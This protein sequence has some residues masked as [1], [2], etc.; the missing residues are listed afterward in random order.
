MS[1]TVVLH[2]RSG[3]R[4]DK[5]RGELGDIVVFAPD[6]G[7]FG[8]LWARVEVL[9]TVILGVSVYPSRREMGVTYR[10]YAN[11][12]SFRV[13]PRPASSQFTSPVDWT[14]ATTFVGSR[15][16]TRTS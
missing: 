13:S 4:V 6:R 11:L 5:R 10:E 16:P 14:L 7:N 12:Q 8:A 15:S 3:R 9:K 1:S 2:D